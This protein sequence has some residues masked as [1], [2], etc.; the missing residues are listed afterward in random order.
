[1]YVHMCYANNYILLYFFILEC[2]GDMEYHR[3]GTQITCNTFSNTDN[4]NN[5]NCTSGLMGCFCISN[6][7]LEDGMCIH[8][9]T[10]PSKF[11]YKQLTNVKHGLNS[12]TG[13]TIF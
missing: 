7:V 1:M 9:D 4:Y 11:Y 8:P 12:Q 13:L 5:S 2:L 3:C 10:C 6:H